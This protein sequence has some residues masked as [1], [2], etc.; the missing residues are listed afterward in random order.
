MRNEAVKSAELKPRPLMMKHN[1]LIKKNLLQLPG[2]VP[3]Q[4]VCDSGLLPS[5]GKRKE[6]NNFLTV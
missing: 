2:S 6:V 1:H 3:E 5:P 4:R